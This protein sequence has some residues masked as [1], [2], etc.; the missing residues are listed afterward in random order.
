VKTVRPNTTDP[1]PL[2]NS[3]PKM[4]T[5]MIRFVALLVVAVALLALL[6]SR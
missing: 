6:W 1:I 2:R 3:P 5:I 4:G